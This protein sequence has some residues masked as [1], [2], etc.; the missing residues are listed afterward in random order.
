M[1]RLDSIVRYSE[2]DTGRNMRVSAILDLLQDSCIFQSEE[3]G[4]GV[5]YL[6]ENHRAWVLSSW[7]VVIKRYPKMGE[8]LTAFTWPYNFKSFMGYRNFKIEDEKG[9]VIAYANSIW[10]FLDTQKGRPVKAAED[11]ISRY[12]LEPAFEM[13]CADRKLQL[14][15][16]MQEQEKIRIQR[17]HIDTNQHVNNSKYVMMAEE[18]L[19][20]GFKVGELRAEYKKAAVLMDTIYPKVAINEHQVIVSL[21]NEEGSP[22]AIVEFLEDTK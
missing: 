19:P 11:V 9:E 13:T 6:K 15:E 7:Q 10:V 22:Y 14:R 17:F 18:Y 1:Y 3:V 16:D 2:V 5:D 12:P 8:K 4:V 21:E 20:E